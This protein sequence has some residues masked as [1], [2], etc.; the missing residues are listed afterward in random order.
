MNSLLY[1]ASHRTFRIERAPAHTSTLSR[2]TCLLVSQFL[3]NVVSYVSKGRTFRYTSV[4]RRGALAGGKLNV[5]GT[6]R[7]RARG[8]RHLLAFEKNVIRFDTEVNR[9]LRVT[10]REIERTAKL[11][12]LPSS[13]TARARAMAML[14]A[15]CVDN[16]ILYAERQWF[17]AASLRL[18]QTEKDQLLRDALA[19]A[20]VI[21]SHFSL[22]EPRPGSPLAP[23]TWFVNLE[24]LFEQAVREEL[25]NILK[26]RYVIG[27]GRAEPCRIF[28]TITSEYQANPDYFVRNSEGQVQAVGDA[29]YKVWTG[30]ITAGDLYQLLV[31]S[32]AF[33]SPL[34]FLVFP[35]ESYLS[36]R[37]GD[38]VT[39]SKVWVFGLSV[40]ELKAGVEELASTLGLTGD[41]ND[42]V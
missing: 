26:D 7:F 14:F 5:I 36:V 8:L 33:S 32:A 22:D 25:R 18:A 12:E 10:L 13:E 9:I 35:S 17:V 21:L 20:A 38:A 2:T 28:T 19:L 29:K 37:L 23:R 41:D 15:D 24:T 42:Q 4:L 27:H 1:H 34:S 31:H 11:M 30:S 6:I 40:S 3:D 16:E 39:G